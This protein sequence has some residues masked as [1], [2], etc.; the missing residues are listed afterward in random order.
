M[1]TV[2]EEGAPSGMTRRLNFKFFQRQEG[3]FK[4]SSTARIRAVQVKIFESGITEPRV[5][6]SVKLP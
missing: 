1:I 3:R 2:T 6:E 5:T 4:V